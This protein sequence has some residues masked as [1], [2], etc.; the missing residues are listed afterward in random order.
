LN[1]RNPMSR[2]ANLL[3]VDDEPFVTDVVSRWLA[4]EGHRCATA[5]SA[6]EALELL[7]QSEFDLVVSDIGLPGA[8]G[9]DLLAE[10][11]RRHHDVAVLMQTAVDDRETAIAALRHGAFGYLI[12]PLNEQEVIIAVTGALERQRARILARDYQKTLE[13]AVRDRTREIRRA[14]EEISL[15][16]VTISEFRDIDTG[17]HVRRMGLFAEALA[18]A[19]GWDD[20][21]Q[22]QLRLAAPMH[23]VGKIAVPDSILLKPGRLS[24]GEFEEI[25]KH[26]EVGER[27]LSGSDVPLL[28]I[29]REIARAHHER[30]DGSGYP[31]GLRGTEIPAPARLVAVLDVYD[32][33]TND[34]VYRPA[35]DEEDA[36]RLMRAERGAHFDPEFF[37]AFERILPELRDIRWQAAETETGLD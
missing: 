34:R 3:I 33:L 13:L 28:A 21:L 31:D 35:M 4:G 12:K 37:D 23:D 25:K 5:G 2:R 9:L 17:A 8:S 15:L 30:W 36:L 14:R 11:G 10:I 20:H 27:I 6:E 19:L 26:V 16:L 18:R 1:H 24:P 32:A 7:Q 22:Q 29:A